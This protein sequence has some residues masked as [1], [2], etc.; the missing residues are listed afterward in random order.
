MNMQFLLA[1]CIFPLHIFK[2]FPIV[3]YVFQTCVLQCYCGLL[4]CS[5]VEDIIQLR[6]CSTLPAI[7]AVPNK[8]VYVAPYHMYCVVEGG[9]DT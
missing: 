8:T 7:T 5:H 2:G 4:I 3:H 6:Y 1:L 9:T